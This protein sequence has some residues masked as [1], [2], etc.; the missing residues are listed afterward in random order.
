MSSEEE[1]HALRR[2][3]RWSMNTW[4]CQQLMLCCRQ[5]L[6]TQVEAVISR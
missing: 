2:G 5:C 6:Y 1:H 4:R 3:S